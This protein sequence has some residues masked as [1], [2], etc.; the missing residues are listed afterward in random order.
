MYSNV[1]KKVK[2]VSVNLSQCMEVCQ[3]YW[4]NLVQI[5]FNQQVDIS[6]TLIMYSLLI[7]SLV[8]VHSQM[9]LKCFK[10]F[11]LKYHFIIMLVEFLFCIYN[12]RIYLFI[13]SNNNPFY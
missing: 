2:M 12:V 9:Y 5:Y 6:N 8:G 1:K 4:H 7:S 10:Y 3:K 13:N 11:S